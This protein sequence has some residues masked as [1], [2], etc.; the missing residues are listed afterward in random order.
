M[1]SKGGTSAAAADSMGWNRSCSISFHKRLIVVVATLAK[2]TGIPFDDCDIEP[3]CN[4][5]R[6]GS[7]DVTWLTG[8]WDRLNLEPCE[9]S[10]N[11]CR[12][13]WLN[14]VDNQRKTVPANLETYF[15]A[16]SV[17]LPGI[18]RLLW[19][20]VVPSINE[21]NCD[22]KCPPKPWDKWEGSIEK[23][24]TNPPS[25]FIFPRKNQLLRMVCLRL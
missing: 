16:P 5:K 2:N 15:M 10:D 19:Q 3:N 6:S 4:P 21:A 14:P 8:D 22:T 24:S 17:I 11:L 13:L 12:E 25:W 20:F 18:W 1:W 23:I 9:L 7:Q